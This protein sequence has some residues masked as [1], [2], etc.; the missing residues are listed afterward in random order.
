MT[1]AT[2]RVLLPAHL[3]TLAGVAGE[4]SIVVTEVVSAAAIIDVL[5]TTYPALRGTMRDPVTK[6]RRPF[7]RFFVAS[8][9]ISHQP[10][11]EPLSTNVV[12]GADVFIV[13]GAM[14]GG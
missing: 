12:E 14:A 3:K 9:D 5:E 6:R 2:V 4:V 7:V 10:M 8:E 11:D 1:S 13:V